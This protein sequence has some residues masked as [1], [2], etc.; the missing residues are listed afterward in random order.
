MDL[1][2]INKEL[3]KLRPQE[4]ISWA[5]NRSIHPIVTTNF[6][7]HEAAILHMVTQ[8]QPDIPV[9]WVDSGYA[10]KATYLFA[11]RLVRQL[12]LNIHIYHPS[13]SRSFR[14]AVM[15]GVPEVDTADHEVFT[16]DVKLEPFARAMAEFSPDYWVTAIRRDQTDYRKALDV[17]TKVS[18][19]YYRVAPLL[20]W[21]ELDVEEY[22]VANDLPIEEDYYDPTKV[23]EHRECGL[24]TLTEE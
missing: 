1:D 20:N 8:C 7:P 2:N 17:I 18:G 19:G 15:G 4:I 10:T 9:I 12:E 13:V 14:E 22:L 6:G 21:S 23:Y 16:R 24:H 5:L 3:A 11:D